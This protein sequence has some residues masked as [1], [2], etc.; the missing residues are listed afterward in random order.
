MNFATP[1]YI[2]VPP[3]SHQRST[4]WPSSS[5]GADVPVDKSLAGDF[6]TLKKSTICILLAESLLFLG[7]GLLC[8]AFRDKSIKLLVINPLQRRGIVRNEKRQ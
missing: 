7:T 8:K 4:A 6:R 2:S 3:G 5:L 1:I